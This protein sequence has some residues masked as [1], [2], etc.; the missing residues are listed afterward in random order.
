MTD[1][2]EDED[3]DETARFAANVAW[4][5][6]AN[7]D[8]WHR[9]MLD[10]NWN[11]PLYVLDWI[12]RQADCDLATALTIFWNGQP[13]AW[14]DGE[15]ADDE[16]PNGYSY[17]NAEICVYVAGRVQAGGYSRSQIAFMPN[18]WTK[19]DYVDLVESEKGCAKPRFRAHPDLIRD[20]DGRDVNLDGDFYRRYP[21]RFHL[22]H[23]DEQFSSDL[24]N[25]SF[26]TDRSIATM[27]AV[28][29][30]EQATLRSLPEWLG[31]G[32]KVEVDRSAAPSD[33]HSPTDRTDDT[34]VDAS[35]RIRAMRRQAG[36]R[37]AEVPTSAKT[38]GFAAL[39]RRL[40][41]R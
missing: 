31:G 26:E 36:P 6:S 25:G 29:D 9:V 4:L 14:I 38:S 2:H 5:Q 19:K 12:V 1:A 18:T 16:E 7:P 8:D 13:A 35:A 22:S 28:D 17:L 3:E 21:S 27:K 41:G 39:L 37:P 10:F 40:F 30:A 15:G 24:E 32:G 23:Y 34:D 20:R 33:N 11:E